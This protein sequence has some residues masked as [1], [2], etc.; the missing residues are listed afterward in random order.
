MSKCKAY[1]PPKQKYRSQREA[2]HHLGVAFSYGK[3]GLGELHTYQCPS[4]GFW[5]LGHPK[6]YQPEKDNTASIRAE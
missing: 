5:H 6:W 1:N 3:V 2:Q 4:C